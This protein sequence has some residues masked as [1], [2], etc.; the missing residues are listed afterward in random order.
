MKYHKSVRVLFFIVV[1]P[2]WV[3]GQDQHYTITG[4]ISHLNAP[5]KAYLFYDET[6]DSAGIKDGHFQ[7]SGMIHQPMSAHLVV[8]IRGTGPSSVQIGYIPFKLLFY[9]EQGKISIT[10]PDTIANATV[11]GGPLNTDYTKFRAL[12]QPVEEAFQRCS[13]DK[14][15]YAVGARQKQLYL[16]FIKDNPGSLM[17]LFLLRT[18]AGFSSLLIPTVISDQPRYTAIDSLY[19][20][21]DRSVVTSRAGVELGEALAR[22][23]R[24]AI[25]A[26]APDFSQTDTAGRL[27]S[28]HDFKGKYVLID[29]WASWCSPCRS[30]NP[31][32]VKAYNKYRSK[33]FAILGVSLNSSGERQQWLK[34][35]R[36]DGL[37]WPQ[38]SD[39]KGWKNEV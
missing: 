11:A 6:I 21:L 26:M 18:Y 22:K 15:M 19:S 7:F 2:A 32:L 3:F 9:L 24:V 10:S 33:G 12:L 25:G 35:I 27:I 28:L 16:Q 14:Q 34:A 30:E 29:F 39:L 37:T 17:S 8:N 23:K 36:A 13:D 20:S 31:N 38:I 4:K 1:L 5:A